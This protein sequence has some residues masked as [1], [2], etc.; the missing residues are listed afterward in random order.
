MPDILLMPQPRRVTYADGSYVL[1][2]SGLI[3]IDRPELLFEAQTIQRAVS[4]FADAQWQI[5]A[6]S[7]YPEIVLHLTIDPTLTKPESYILSVAPDG[8]T[9]RGADAAGVFYG[10]CTLSQLVQQGDG[11]V[12]VVEIQDDP[13]Y[14]A[15]G[16]MLDISRDRV[17]KM[18]TL[19]ALIDMLASWKIN[20]LQLYMEHTFA[21]RNHPEVWAKASPITGQE[22]L[23]LDV[24]CRQRHINLVPNQNS[25]GHMERWLKFERYLPLAECP[26]GF[27]APWRREGLNPPSTLDPTDPGSLELIFSLYDELLPHFTSALFN[28]GGDE[29]WELGQCKSKQAVEE[30]GGRV[31]LDYLLKLHENVSARGLKMQFWADIIVH[32]PDLVPELPRDIVP[33]VWGYEA[34]QPKE[35]DCEMVAKAGLPFYVVPGT[36]SWNT[37]SGRTGVAMQNLRTAAKNGHKH[38]AVGYLNTDWGDNGHWQPL[39][40]SYLGFAYGAALA[41]YYDGNENIDLPRALDLFAFYDVN[42]QMGRVAYDLGSLYEIVGPSN[43]NGQSLAYMLQLPQDEIQKRVSE[44]RFQLSAENL[45]AA[46]TRIDE[47]L[48][49]LHESSMQTPEAGLIRAEYQQAADLLRHSAERGLIF[50]GEQTRTPADL[51]RE[52]RVL[53]ARQQENWLARHRYGGLEDSIARFDP[54]LNE[55]QAVVG[56]NS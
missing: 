55:Y 7:H 1:P 34:D 52:L 9:V 19:Y 30:R 4:R 48:D 27:L 3:A 38:G 13:D 49:R 10:V 47:V 24:Y 53:I 29:P 56:S 21:Y 54:L 23:E 43:I 11:A 50:F 42:Q 44:N 2:T 45:R 20:E 35:V 17:P 18:E 39:S 14:P 46:I 26:D 51:L 5:V 31:Y 25:L 15:R 41:W 40:V 12:P 6:G 22:I 32:Y 33:M 8:I 36:S 16:V 28:V 37:I